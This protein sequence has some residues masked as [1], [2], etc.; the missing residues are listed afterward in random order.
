VQLASDI[1]QPEIRLDKNIRFHPDLT[2]G[3]KIFLAEIQ[4]IISHN[5]SKK[6]HYTLRKLSEMFGV[7]HQTAKNWIKK[8]VNLGFLEIGFNYDAQGHRQFLKACAKI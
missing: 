2:F 8:L 1:F 3:E 5:E 7:S 4:S 6:F